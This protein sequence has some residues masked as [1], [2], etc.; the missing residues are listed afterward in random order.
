[1]PYIRTRFS[2]IITPEQE[3]ELKAG[4]GKAIALIPGKTENWLMLDFED[5]CR[6]WFRGEQTSPMAMVEVSIF[7]STSQEAYD[8]LTSGITAL[9]EKVLGLSPDALYIKYAE[10]THWGWNGENCT[11]RTAA[12]IFFIRFICFSFLFYDSADT[13]FYCTFQPFRHSAYHCYYT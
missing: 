3:I 10:T 6:L 4:L 2:G 7:G 5:R 12:A 13:G 9:F 11:A 1:M 8:R